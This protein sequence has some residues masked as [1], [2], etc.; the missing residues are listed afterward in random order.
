MCIQ[1]RKAK[2]LGIDLLVEY[3]NISEFEN[4]NLTNIFSAYIINLTFNL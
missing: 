2:S 4:I 3:K 1:R